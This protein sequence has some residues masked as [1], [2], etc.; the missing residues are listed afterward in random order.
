MGVGV[1]DGVAFPKLCDVGFDDEFPGES[2]RISD[3]RQVEFEIPE[4]FDDI[5]TIEGL[6][7]DDVFLHRVEEF[8]GFAGDANG[9]VEEVAFPV[10][11][12][13]EDIFP[14]FNSNRD[15]VGIGF[16]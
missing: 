15:E 11:E 13:G 16:F 5:F 6:S 8:A 3:T 9:H 1:G 10:V 12:A 14:A 4:F 7:V 2:E